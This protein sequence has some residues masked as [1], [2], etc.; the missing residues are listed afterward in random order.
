MTLIAEPTT[1]TVPTNVGS[2]ARARLR[3]F[4]RPPRLMGVDVARGLAIVGM[5]GAHVG[6]TATLRWGDPTT[7]SGIVNGRSSILFALV[8]GI[9]LALASGGQQRPHGEALRRARLRMA[10]RALVVL[11]VGLALELMGGTI[12]IILPVYGM[13]FLVTIPFL[14]LRRRTL[15]ITAASAAVAG[16]AMLA[17][18]HLLALGQ[19]GPGV[20]LLLTGA[21]PL[22]VWLPLMLAGIALGRSSL[23]SIKAGVMLLVVGVVLAVT[24]YAVGNTVSTALGGATESNPSGSVTSGSSPSG[25]ATTG[26][27][28]QDMPESQTKPGEQ[29]DLS[30][31]TCQIYADGYTACSPPGAP[32]GSSVVHVGSDG[33]PGYLK[34]FTKEGGLSTVP[35]TALAVGPHSGGTFEILGS[36]GF[37]LAVLGACL[38]LVRPLRWLLIPI[39]A[40]G[41]M[42][43]TAYT[44]HVVSCVLLV[45][46]LALAPQLSQ[47]TTLGGNGFWLLSIASLL[48]GC[49][50]WAITAGRGPMERLAAWGAKRVDGAGAGAR[51]GAQENAE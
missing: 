51:R 14:G 35:A 2:S 48:T 20:D 43:L 10:G 41:T 40:A 42:P 15:L 23:G 27:A 16:P 36:G 21:Y 32:Q 19:G 18:V 5:I 25:E 7:W 17:T 30:G 33:F 3:E 13:L 8:A 45:S 22:T 26:T 49:T 28:A 6:V 4:G 39:A 46:P 47:S 50:V 29:V 37:A 12:A 38:L 31:K 44:L 1:A 9:S 34:S 11:S 24:A